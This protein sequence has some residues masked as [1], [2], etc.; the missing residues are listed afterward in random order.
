MCCVGY[1]ACFLTSLVCVYA[2]CIVWLDLRIIPILSGSRLAQTCAA[3]SNYFPAI[4]ECVP[5]QLASTQAFLNAY[6][7]VKTCAGGVV[8]SVDKLEGLRYCQVV[9]GSLTI[10]VSDVNADYSALY[11][12]RQIQGWS[13][14]VWFGSLLLYHVS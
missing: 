14:G 4:D 10:A 2:G 3:G 6:S 9:T 8:D 1:N 13:F 7:F 11:D 12:I 5:L